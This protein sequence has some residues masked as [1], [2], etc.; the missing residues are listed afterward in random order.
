MWTVQRVHVTGTDSNGVEEIS[1][2]TYRSEVLEDAERRLNLYARMPFTRRIR[3][4]WNGKLFAVFSP[5]PSDDSELFLT[6]PDSLRGRVFHQSTF[7]DR[8]F[9]NGSK[10]AKVPLN[11]V[12]PERVEGC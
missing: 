3:V 4:L 7:S 12:E 1:I 11:Q 9:W 8:R 2:Q 5:D 10:E 6:P